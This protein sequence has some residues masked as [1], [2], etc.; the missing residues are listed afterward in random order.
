MSYFSDEYF[1]V[2]VV[3][4]YFISQLQNLPNYKTT[5]VIN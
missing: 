1:F 4:W 5:L 3:I 2:V